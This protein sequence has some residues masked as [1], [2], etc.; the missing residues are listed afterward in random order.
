M[1]LLVIFQTTNVELLILRM[2]WNIKGPANSIQWIALFDKAI[3][4]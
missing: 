3:E 1:I 2:K 4:N